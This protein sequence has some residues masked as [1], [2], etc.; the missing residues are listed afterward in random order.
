MDKKQIEKGLTVLIAVSA[1]IVIIEFAFIAYC[2]GLA[3]L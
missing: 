3:A 1:I 2:G